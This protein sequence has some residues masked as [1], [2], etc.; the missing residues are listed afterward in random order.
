LIKHHVHVLHEQLLESNLIRII[1]PYSC[2]ELDHMAV[3]LDLLAGESDN[4]SHGL[5]L[6]AQQ[7]I[8]A[9]WVYC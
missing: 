2:V 4:F 1:E 8:T 9:T 7:W 6:A 3:I 5:V